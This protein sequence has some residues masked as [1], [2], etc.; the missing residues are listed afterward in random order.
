[1]AKV[2]MTYGQLLD[3]V[4]PCLEMLNGL[5][6][7]EQT[8]ISHLFDLADNL[9]AAEDRAKA[10]WD[11]R[12][13]LIEPFI[14]KDKDGELKKETDENGRENF[15][16]TDENREEWGKKFVELRDTEVEIDFKKLIK[17]NFEGAKECKPLYLKGI[18]LLVK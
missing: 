17:K 12:E 11:L 1:M 13:K 10:F 8:P 14:E 3:E 4:K 6:Y 15:V 16:M 18:R 2:K 5:D 9:S 7:G